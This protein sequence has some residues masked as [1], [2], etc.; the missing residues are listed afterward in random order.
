MFKKMINSDKYK[1]NNR[2]DTRPEARGASLA[3]FVTV[4]TRLQRFARTVF[5]QYKHNNR[6]DT[7][8]EAQGAFLAGFLRVLTWLQRFAGIVFADEC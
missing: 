4:L 8:P 3:G 7:P 2:P 6:P 5:V 1:H